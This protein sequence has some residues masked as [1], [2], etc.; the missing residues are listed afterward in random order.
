[1]DVP[2]SIN[3]GKTL[4]HENR[5]RPEII[6]EPPSRIFRAFR[7]IRGP[8]VVSRLNHLCGSRMQNRKKFDGEA[9]NSRGK[10]HA[11]IS[12]SPRHHKDGPER[13]GHGCFKR[14]CRSRLALPLTRV[15][16]PEGAICR[17]PCL[18]AED[19]A[20]P[21]AF[22]LPVHCTG[23][24][25][26]FRYSRWSG[27]IGF[28]CRPSSHA[29]EETSRLCVV[30]KCVSQCFDAKAYGFRYGVHQLEG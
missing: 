10:G 29:V 4:V 14:R 9:G 26:A 16:D 12:T 17:R 25:S 23:S 28:R 1:M 21:A 8:I 19:D 20:R 22:V 27:P 30:E 15:G 5:E 2:S 11:G 18:L 3:P 24:G 13:S 6:R 7:G